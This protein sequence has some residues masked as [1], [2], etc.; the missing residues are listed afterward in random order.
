MKQKENWS[1]VSVAI[2]TQRKDKS[3]PCK[4]N[5]MFKARKAIKDMTCLGNSK[6]F[7]VGGEDSL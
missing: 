5:S 3:I 4:W 6:N 7:G 1:E 2:T